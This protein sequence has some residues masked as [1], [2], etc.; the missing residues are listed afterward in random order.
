MTAAVTLQPATPADLP[1]RIGE[2]SDRPFIVD[3]WRKSFRDAPGYREMH[4]GDYFPALGARIDRLL[5]TSDV[6]VAEL[7]ESAGAADPSMDREIGFIVFDGPVLHYL[8]VRARV[9]GI[10]IG[11]ALLSAANQVEPLKVFTHWS[12]P[13]REPCTRIFRGMRYN[14]FRG[15]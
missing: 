14:P 5:E 10:G 8:F 7:P 1:I 4:A 13:L 11:R 15:L 2:P 6:L 12:R 3:A 9:Q